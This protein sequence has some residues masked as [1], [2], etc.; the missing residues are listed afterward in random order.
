LGERGNARGG[1]DD[2]GQPGEGGVEVGADTLLD[3]GREKVGDRDSG[4]N[5][6]EANPDRTPG[7]EAKAKRPRRQLCS[8]PIE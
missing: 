7:D 6:R 1:I 2:R 3:V 8:S 4:Q 5:Q